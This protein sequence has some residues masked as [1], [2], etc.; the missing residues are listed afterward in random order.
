MTS[1]TDAKTHYSH[2]HIYD[3]AGNSLDFNGNI[4]NP[5]SPDAHVPLN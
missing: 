2:E 1:P 4:V 3:E 5:K